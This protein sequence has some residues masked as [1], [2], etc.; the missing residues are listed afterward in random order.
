MRILFQI[1]TSHANSNYV[2]LRTEFGPEAYNL[3]TKNCN[4]FANALVYTLLAKQI[5]TYVN[6]LANLGSFVSCLLPK[7]MLENA[8]V[9]GD[10]NNGSSSSG[11][12]VHTRG[13]MNGKTSNCATAFSGSGT[14][15]GTSSSSSGSGSGI[16]S[17]LGNV[18]G[19]GGSLAENKGTN[20]LTDRREKA[21]RAAMTRL[22]DDEKSR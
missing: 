17:V 4:H 20:D 6:R 16:R 15:L 21:R 7:K 8:P 9:G 12:Q 13:A 2:D 19:F 18:G 14:T 1:L 11:F 10:T 3:I 22:L 5:P